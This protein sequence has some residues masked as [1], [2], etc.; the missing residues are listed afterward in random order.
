MTN[1]VFVNFFQDGSIS[2]DSSDDPDDIIFKN[3]SGEEI[4]RIITS[5]ED[6]VVTVDTDRSFERP[7]VIDISQYSSVFPD[8]DAA[9]VG[10]EVSGTIG[11]GFNFGFEWVYFFDGADAGEIVSYFK[12]GANLGI[13]A[14]VGVYGFVAGSSETPS[15]ESWKGWFFSLSGGSGWGGGVF[16]S[17]A[18]NKDE[19]YPGQ[20]SRTIWK[21]YSTT[22]PSIVPTEIRIGGKWSKTYYWRL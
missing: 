21:G 1:H 7:I 2:G 3:R 18:D 20:H 5:G 12:A 19:L 16:W 14:G 4:G 13:E 22:S 6:V 8:I 11:G 17:N 9:G 15:A 10:V